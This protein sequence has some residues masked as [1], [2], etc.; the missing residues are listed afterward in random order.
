MVCLYRVTHQLA[1]AVS[2]IKILLCFHVDS[3]HDAPIGDCWENA[4]LSVC[5]CMR[6]R[7]CSL[8]SNSD[9]SRA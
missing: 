5:I 6:H 1:G 7:M 4:S 8:A 9:A 2:L 3:E